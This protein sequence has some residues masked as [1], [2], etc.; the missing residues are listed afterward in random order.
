MTDINDIFSL[1]KKAIQRVLF[2][3]IAPFAKLGSSK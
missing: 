2:S 1:I 3:F